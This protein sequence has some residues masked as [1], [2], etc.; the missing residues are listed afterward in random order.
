LAENYEPLGQVMLGTC[1][2]QHKS[3]DTNKTVFVSAHCH[4]SNAWQNGLTSNILVT[5]KRTKWN[6]WSS[7]Y[8]N[9]N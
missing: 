3:F 5:K 6:Y 8:E 9:M 7:F 4:W 2:T 1:F